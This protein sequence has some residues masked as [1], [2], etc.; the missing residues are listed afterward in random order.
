VPG[1]RDY[2]YTVERDSWGP[3]RAD[4][5]LVRRPVAHRRAGHGIARDGDA[6][7]LYR[8]TFTPRT[9]LAELERYA[10]QL[11]IVARHANE[12]TLGCFLHVETER[13]AVV[14]TLYERWF[15][16][17]R[18]RCEELASRSFDPSDD[19]ALVASAEF[20]AELEDWAE[21]RNDERALDQA[22][23]RAHEDDRARRAL[24]DADAAE[25][26]ARI[27]TPD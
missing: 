15:D 8:R 26:L 20:V 3:A 24:E 19:G 23:A 1:P 22:E 14:I 18:L 10:A 16:G 13:G 6:R 11:A 4:V 7:V 21:R 12:G 2:R 27:L 25:R 9:E 5:A 17:R